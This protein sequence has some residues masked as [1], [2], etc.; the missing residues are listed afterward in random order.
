MSHCSH[1]KEPLLGCFKKRTINLKTWVNIEEV[2]DNNQS[3]GLSKDS[4][5]TLKMRMKLTSNM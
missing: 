5:E 2:T 4:Q 3:R 1:S